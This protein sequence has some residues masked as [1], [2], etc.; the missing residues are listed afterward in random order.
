MTHRLQ[1]QKMLNAG[2]YTRT[3]EGMTYTVLYRFNQSYKILITPQY[4]IIT[5]VHDAPN[6]N[7]TAL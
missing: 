2:Q 6:V 5:Y 4:K 1:I 3:F 7:A